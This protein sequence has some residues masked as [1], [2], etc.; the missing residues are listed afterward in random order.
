MILPR[1]AEIHIGKVEGSE[2]ILARAAGDPVVYRLSYDLAEYVPVSL[3]AFRN[4]FL[5][6]PH[7][8]EPAPEAEEEDFEEILSPSEES[9]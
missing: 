6:E 8:E 5:A 9:P 3:E 2:W 4:R 1:L 7:A